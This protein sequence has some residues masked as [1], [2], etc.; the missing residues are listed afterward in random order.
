M[1][2]R[3]YVLATITC[4]YMEQRLEA[5]LLL[6]PKQSMGIPSFP[7]LWNLSGKKQLGKIKGFQLWDNLCA[8]TAPPPT[9]AL[10]AVLRGSLGE[11]SSSCGE[12]SILDHQKKTLKS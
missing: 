7:P 1:R 6:I 5:G 9:T 8:P 3:R 4:C 12:D 10:V 11:V 2:D